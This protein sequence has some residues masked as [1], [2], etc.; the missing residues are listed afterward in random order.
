MTALDVKTLLDVLNRILSLRVEF[1]REGTTLAPKGAQ[2]PRVLTPEPAAGP[3]GRAHWR[4]QVEAYGLARCATRTA[5]LE[6]LDHA[7]EVGISDAQAPREP[8]PT[9]L[10]N[11]F[12]VGDD[13]ELTGLTRREDGFHS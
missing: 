8:V 5:F 1:R 9:A 11:L 3:C 2:N 10:G 12:A 6:Q 7:I 4:L 13:L